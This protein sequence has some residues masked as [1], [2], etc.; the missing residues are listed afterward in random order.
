[1]N[2]INRLEEVKKYLSP[3]I[4]AVISSVERYELERISEIRLRLGRKLTLSAFSKEF[5]LSKSGT[6]SNSC[7]S[8]LEVTKEDIEYTYRLALKNS[9]HSFQREI[10]QG[11]I[12]V[13]GGS[14]IGFCGTA[15]KENDTSHSVKTLK[16]ISSIN[17]RLGREVKGCSDKLF[18]A[19]FTEQPE[20]LLLI[21]PPCSGKTTVLRDIARRVGNEYTTSI[22][23]ERNEIAA[24]YNGK[25]QNDIGSKTDVFSSYSR[26]DGIMTAVRVMSPSYLICDEIG[27]REDYKA[28][29][30]ALCSG[31]KL[32]ASCHSA[33][34]E[35]AAQKPVIRK[36][37]KMKAF[38]SY[39]VL[40]T[41]IN[42]GKLIDSGSFD[43]HLSEHKKCLL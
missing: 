5:F 40:G 39:A 29:E 42:C 35:R 13:S 26:F 23:D 36:L 34:A 21:G 31:V 3:N 17:I 4:C 37:L 1:M 16:D 24:V 18:S 43:K 33:S 27:S 22:V 15:V 6:L 9:V 14:R 12:T 11:Y 25:P 19:L 2:T 41:G 10:S 7:E 20:S 28:L 32:I 38:E 8:A 30:Y